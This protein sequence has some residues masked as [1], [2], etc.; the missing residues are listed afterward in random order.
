MKYELTRR[1][2][3]ISLVMPSSPKRKCR[4]GS[5]NGEFRIGLSMTTS[6]RLS[7]PRWRSGR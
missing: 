4:R 3:A 1:S 7:Q 2:S 5:S 6:A